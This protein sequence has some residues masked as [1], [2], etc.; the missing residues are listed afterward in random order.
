MRRRDFVSLLGGAATWPLAALAQQRV[1]RIGVVMA[2]A[3]S[4]PNG[5]MQITAFRQ[6][7]QNWVGQKAATFRSTSALVRAIPSASES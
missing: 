5:R 3:E 4:D 1:R 6:H 2:Y 7:L